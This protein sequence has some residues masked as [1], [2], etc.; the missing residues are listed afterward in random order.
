VLTLAIQR[1]PDMLPRR[2]F[3]AGISIRAL[4]VHIDKT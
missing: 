4:D 2:G 1:L 3:A